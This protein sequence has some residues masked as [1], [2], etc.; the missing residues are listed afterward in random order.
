MLSTKSF[1]YSSC[2]RLSF[3]FLGLLTMFKAQPRGEAFSIWVINTTQSAFVVVT[4]TVIL[5]TDISNLIFHY[6]FYSRS[7]TKIYIFKNYKC[8]VLLKVHIHTHTHTH[9]H[10]FIIY[11]FDFGNLFFS[12]RGK[13]LARWRTTDLTCKA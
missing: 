5:S 10:M 8:V 6:A 13:D 9:T 3:L 11:E 4:F 12:K 7:V 1:T 2:D